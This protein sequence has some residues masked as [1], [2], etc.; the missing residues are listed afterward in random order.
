MKKVLWI[1]LAVLWLGCSTSGT[2]PSSAPV[3]AKNLSA[4]EQPMAPRAIVSTPPPPAHVDPPKPPNPGGD[5]LWRAG[6]YQFRNGRYLWTPGAWVNPPRSG[7]VWVPGFFERTP[8]G[9]MF[10]NGHWRTG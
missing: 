4:R 3:R 6:H 2:R 1:A 8:Q 9:G 5:A 7:L 10:V